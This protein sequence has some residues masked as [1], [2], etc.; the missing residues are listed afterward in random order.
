MS[1]PTLLARPFRLSMALLV[2]I[3]LLASQGHAQTETKK[4]RGFSDA[5]KAAISKQLE[6]AV[7]RGDTPGVVAL[8]V[9]REGV[10]YEGAAGK[11]DLAQNRAMPLNG[12]FNIASMTKP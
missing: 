4:S 11:A 6:A 10:I 3:C 8:V 7:S 9:D 5:G 2:A 12:I 1:T